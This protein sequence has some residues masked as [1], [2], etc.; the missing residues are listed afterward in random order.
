[1]SLYVNVLV[2]LERRQM[3]KQKGVQVSITIRH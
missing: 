2:R 1:M 3:P